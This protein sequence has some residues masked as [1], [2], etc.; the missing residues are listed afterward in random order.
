MKP[1]GHSS[2]LSIF[3]ILSITLFCSNL[4]LVSSQKIDEKYHTKTTHLQ[5]MD[6]ETIYRVSKSLCW[7]CIKES[8]EFLFANNLVRAKKGELP[9]AYDL[10]LDKYANW[11]AGQ[12]KTDCKLQHSFPEDGFQLGENIFWG[13]GST[14]TPTD[15]VKV[16]ADEEKY[17]DYSTNTCVV[18]Q[19]CGHYTQIVWSATRRIGCARVICDNGDV[20][21]TCNY[22]P[23]GNYIGQRPY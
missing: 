1:A 10:Q 5:N 17:Y 20:F 11:W 12:R 22:D 13:S 7:G 15:A 21:I 3:L 16:W 2:T 18:G 14:W 4:P 23:P 19:M 8:I 9:L 6:N